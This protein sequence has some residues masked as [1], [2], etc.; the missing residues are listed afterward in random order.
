MRH[1]PVKRPVFPT[2]PLK[3]AKEQCEALSEG[4]IGPK[5]Q[6]KKN[7]LAYNHLRMNVWAMRNSCGNRTSHSYAMP[8]SH[9]R[10]FATY[11][12]TPG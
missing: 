6:T 9:D 5:K 12:N 11:G 2:V 4:E 1:P 10:V 3:Y 7:V 8:L